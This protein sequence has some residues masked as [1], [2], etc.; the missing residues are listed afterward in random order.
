MIQAQCFP[1]GPDVI[2]MVC[3]PVKMRRGL[4]EILKSMGHD[5]NNIIIFY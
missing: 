5:E 1:A 2:T 4:I 3:G